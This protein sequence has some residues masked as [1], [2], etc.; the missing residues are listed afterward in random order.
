MA[1]TLENAITLSLSKKL[2][3]LG[4]LLLLI[5]AA[6]WFGIISPE[7]EE[8]QRKN[9]EY[10]K[11][12]VDLDSKKQVAEDPKEFEAK[13]NRL[14]KHLDV[15]KAQLPDEKE[16]PSLLRTI[17]SLGKESGL[18][19]QLFQ[20]RAEIQKDFYAEIP[21]QIQMVGGF[22]DVADFFYKVGKLDRIVNITDF[23]M[24]KPKASEDGRMMM[25]TSCLATT[26]RFIEEPDNPQTGAK[27]SPK[28]TKKKAGN[29]KK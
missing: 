12:K 1:F 7:R 5:F 22:H 15:M 8:V 10:H 4:V 29:K 19:F 9:K 11:L 13:L 14:K 28:K 18:S 6:F 17:S 2:G 25:T 3:I 26:F 24:A 20:P 21:V 27:N 23:S 16:I